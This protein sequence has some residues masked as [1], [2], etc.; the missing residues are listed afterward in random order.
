M[1]GYGNATQQ[2]A[3][4]GI[5]GRGRVK[6]VFPYPQLAHIWAQQTQEHGR[7][8][9]GQMY[10]HG[11]TIYSYG[12]HYP[13]ARFTDAT[14]DGQRVVL[15]NEEK[16]SNTTERHKDFVRNALNG[17]PVRVFTVPRVDAISAFHPD[18]AR[19]LRDRFDSH[20]A[21]MARAHVAVWHGWN[22]DERI[23]DTAERRIESLPSYANDLRDYC[24]AFNVQGVD[25]DESAAI[26]K[27][28]AAFARYNDPKRVAKRE[29]AKAAKPLRAWKEAAK[30]AAW[31]EGVSTT[32]PNFHFVSYHDKQT[33]AARFGLSYYEM[34]RRV[35]N[36]T[37]RRENA[38]YRDAR[39]TLTAAQWLAG[40]QGE[41]HQ[42]SPTL[43]RR[44]GDTLETSR[45][46]N[47]PFSHAVLAF[48]KAQQ[49]RSTNTTWQRNGQQ[50]RV[51]HFN[52]DSID[53]QG[54]MRAGCHTLKWEEM[55]RLAIQEVPHMV[56]PCFGLPVAL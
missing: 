44:I 35:D 2:I 53:A 40:R 8:P 51:G 16:N 14:L 31:L 11:D 17:L 42:E 48:L 55:L 56:K 7:S 32:L 1:F 12:R 13:I 29:A 26:A 47:C 50:I 5:Q 28:N 37:R 30:F 19:Y 43:V 49:C 41:F 38:R 27:I 22:G 24:R 52:V 4:T 25:V 21:R 15:F 23:E 39:K 46:A 36:E 6:Q 10:F 3:A 20:V 54:N 18:N 33:I 45:G 34:E 9:K